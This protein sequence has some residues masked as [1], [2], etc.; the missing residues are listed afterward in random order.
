MVHVERGEG[1]AEALAQPGEDMEQDDRIHA[2]GEPDGN[3]LLR[4]GNARQ[5][6][7]GDAG[8]ISAPRFP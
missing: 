5:E 6:G 2:A 1:K 7:A 4:E 8:G 3:A